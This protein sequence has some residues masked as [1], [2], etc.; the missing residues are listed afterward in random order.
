MQTVAFSS[1]F[2]WDPGALSPGRTLQGVLH[3]QLHQWFV[4]YRD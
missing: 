2:F 3:D 1:G 4:C